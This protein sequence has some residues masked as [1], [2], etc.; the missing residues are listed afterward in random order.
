MNSQ[1]KTSSEKY[2]ARQITTAVLAS[3]LVFASAGCA[4]SPSFNVL[5]SYFP[6]WIACMVASILL[7]ALVRFVLNRLQ[8]EQRVPALPLFYFAITLLIACLIWLIAFE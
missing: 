2:P 8:W 7:T 1:K 5:G 6:G 4:H 3:T